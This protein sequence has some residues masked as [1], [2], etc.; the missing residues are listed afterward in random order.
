MTSEEKAEVDG[1]VG[2]DCESIVRRLH[3]VYAQTLYIS[4]KCWFV[5]RKPSTYIM[6]ATTNLAA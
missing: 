3:M 1:W 2:R 5:H 6:N 4:D